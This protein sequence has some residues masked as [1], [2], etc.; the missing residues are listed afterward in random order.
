MGFVFQSFIF[1][2]YLSEHAAPTKPSE[3]YNYD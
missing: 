2:L 3:S 1:M